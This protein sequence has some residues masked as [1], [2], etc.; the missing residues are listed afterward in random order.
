MSDAESVTGLSAKLSECPSSCA[1]VLR[2]TL[3]KTP[4]AAA[5]VLLFNLMLK[6][7][8]PGVYKPYQAAE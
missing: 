2:E 7:F 6:V 4:A 3:A 5:R 1:K 8:V